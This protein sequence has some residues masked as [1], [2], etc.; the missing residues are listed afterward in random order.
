V[1]RVVKK[2]GV[3]LIPALFWGISLVNAGDPGSSKDPLVSQSYVEDRIAYSTSYCDNLFSLSH[4][5]IV[6]VTAGQKLMC[7][8][9]T[10]F[11]LRSGSGNAVGRNLGGIC[12]ITSGV[13]LVTG[14]PVKKNHLIL[15]PRDDARGFAAASDSVLMVKGRHQIE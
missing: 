13:D 4:F 10:E 1:L 11:I 9:G 3:L 15:I 5:K 6:D 2:V 14:A 7:S 8:E 12:D